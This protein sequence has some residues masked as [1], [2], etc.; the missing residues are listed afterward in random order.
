MSTLSAATQDRKARLAQ[1]KSLKRKQPDED[2]EAAKD[3]P[4][5]EP[6][7][8]KKS[9]DDDKPAEGEEP[10]EDDAPLA[11]ASPFRSPSTVSDAAPKHLSGRNYDSS[12]RGPRLGFEIAPSEG[13]ETL[14][15]R[16][17]EIATSTKA[18]AARD[19]A[20]DKPLDLFKLQPKRPNWDLKRDLELKLEVLNVRTENAVARLVRERIQ[21][22]ARK[23]REVGM[24]NGRIREAEAD[25]VDVDEEG[26]EEV[27][28]EGTTLVEA[29]KERE[30]EDEEEVERE[31]MLEEAYLD[32]S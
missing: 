22:Q 24:T 2:R 13:Q 14:E 27:G 7:K 8:R 10:T 12:T 16:A 26:N 18:Q 17:E 30:R 20:E 25:K 28:M 1:L 15:R 23:A 3:T 31:R 11:P 32:G 19:E 6:L 4:T 29:T 9:V 5:T 21:G